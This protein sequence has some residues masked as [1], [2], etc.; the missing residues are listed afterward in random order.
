MKDDVIPEG[1]R[2]VLEPPGSIHYARIID[3]EGKTRGWQARPN[4]T[5]RR[6][7]KA[8][9]AAARAAAERGALPANVIALAFKCGRLTVDDQRILIAA[10][11]L[12][13]ATGKDV[14]CG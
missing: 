1:W 5:H 6:L 7:D 13:L 10:V 11:A 2:V 12:V 14:S 9:R 8:L 3:G 4:D